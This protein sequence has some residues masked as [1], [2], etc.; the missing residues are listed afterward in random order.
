MTKVV[1]ALRG[2]GAVAQT[3]EL[4]AAGV[5]GV[6]LASEVASGSIIRVRRGW[7]ALPHADAE[8][9]RAVRVG[10]RLACVSAARFY[11]WATPEHPCLHVSVAA[12]ASRLRVAGDERSAH[13]PGHV[14]GVVVHWQAS[15]SQPTGTRLVTSRRE[16][17]RQIALCQPPEYTVVAC[18]SF[19]HAEPLEAA[20]L[21][22]W[23]AELPAT[24]L[25][26]LQSRSDLCHSFLESIGRIRL[27]NAGITG[28]HQ[29]QIRGVGRVDL[30]IDG[31]LVIEWDGL[32]HHD[33]ARAH[34]EDCRRDAV[35]ATM[36]YRCLRFT[37]TLV[38]NHW[39]LVYAAI[40][41]TLDGITVA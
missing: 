13:P 27:A 38:V 6:G 16:T 3:R 20:E 10:G 7:Y 35:L 1:A 15:P 2:L 37:Y 19:L 36:G 12:N 31:W 21:E 23:L 40:R 41:A 11:G 26:E 14:P 33:N 17:I 39:H 5:T 8:L 4:A 25:A 24:V 22:D 18:D 30:L 34:D 28:D 32:E 29:V 9:V